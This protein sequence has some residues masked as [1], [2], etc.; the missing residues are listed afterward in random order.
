MHWLNHVK[1]ESQVPPII[2]KTLSRLSDKYH[3]ALPEHFR[4]WLTSPTVSTVWTLS[5]QSHKSHQALSESCR[6]WVTSPTNHSM[7]PFKTESQVSSNTSWTLSRLI[8][9][10]LQA[11]YKPFQD[12][13]SSIIKHSLNLSETESQVPQSTLSS[14]LQKYNSVSFP[15][16]WSW[17]WTAEERDEPGVE[18][19]LTLIARQS[20]QFQWI[21][22]GIVGL[23]EYLSFRDDTILVMRHLSLTTHVRRKIVSWVDV[24]A[25]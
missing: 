12:W 20:T 13:V 14:H 23:G 15:W 22:G 19:I 10:S 3:K 21:L 17:S 24:T 18:V 9:K 1:T 25:L 2:L 4:D 6:D 7:N 16:G 11:F 8:H 5:R